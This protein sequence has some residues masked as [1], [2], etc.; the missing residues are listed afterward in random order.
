MG[1]QEEK[2]D[3]RKKTSVAK[4]LVIFVVFGNFFIASLITGYNLSEAWKQNLLNIQKSFDQIKKSVGATI[5]PSLYT[6][7]EDQTNKGL[8]GVVTITDIVQAKLYDMDGVEEL[9]EGK[10]PDPNYIKDTD[11]LKKEDWGTESKTRKICWDVVL[12]Q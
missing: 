4:K 8:E 12:R 6:E 5:G 1:D 3:N 7:D 11:N 2:V 10:K 9:E